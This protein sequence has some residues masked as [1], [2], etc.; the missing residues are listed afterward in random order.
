[1][2]R[3]AI[4]AGPGLGLGLE[5]GMG[6]LSFGWLRRRAAVASVSV[7][8]VAGVVAGG[9]ATAPAA[10][11]TAPA[12]AGTGL[13]A[14]GT[15]S[16]ASAAAVTCPGSGVARSIAGPA[17]S[18]ARNVPWHSV[19][20]G[21]ILADLAAS[22][23]ASARGTLYLVSPAGHR[24]RLGAAPASAAL[25]DWS[26]DGTDALFFTQPP[27]SATTGTITVLNLHTG[28][29]TRFT[30][31]SSDPF[32]ELSFTRPAGKQ[33][34]F[35]AGTAA[36]G[37]SLPLQ[38]LTLTRT[39]TLCYPARFSRA[40]DFDGQYLETADGTELVL[41]TQNGLELVAN[42]G[43]PIRSL[44]IHREVGACD[45]LSWWSSGSVLA[46]CAGQLLVYPL[47]GGRPERLTSSGDAAAF[48][49][50]WHLP[51]GIYAEAAACGSTWLERL[52]RN[53]TATR[54][55]IPGAANAG[56]VR[57]LGTDGDQMPLLIG[58]GCDGHVSYSFVDWYNPGADTARTVIGGR[59]G[60]GYV[61][62]AVLFPAG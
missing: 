46:S 7:L 17:G 38:R 14:A 2:L 21:W 23:S 56:T 19:G 28:T 22:Q 45:L 26:G 60:G 20:R 30:V 61:T 48:L 57:S 6:G 36:N 53:G 33:I 1:M 40:G 25:A 11:G 50:A 29:G 9:A 37:T 13:A 47:S 24:Y 54:L 8:A 10:A 3:A 51:S 42:G 4:G 12:A 41:S 32:P 35:Q 15:A 27:G 39:R 44:A 31:F 34:L 59:A 43:Q 62:A 5:A 16:A 58:G 18:W 55:T 52:N 49:G